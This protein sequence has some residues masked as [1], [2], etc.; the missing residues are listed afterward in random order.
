MVSIHF[1]V[2][3]IC[4]LLDYLTDYSRGL[5]GGATAVRWTEYEWNT[6]N[7]ELNIFFRMFYPDL[8]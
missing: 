1:Q 7:F 2:N 3:L 4:Y 6:L 8:S 5:G